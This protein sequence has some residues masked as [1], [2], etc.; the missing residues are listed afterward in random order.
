MSALTAAQFQRVNG[1]SN[2][3]WGWGGEDD[4][5]SNRLRYNGFHIARYPVNI[6]RYTMLGHKKEKANPKRYENLVSGV[7][8]FATDGLNSLR[9]RVHRL[10]KKVLY[11]WIEVEVLAAEAAS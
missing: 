9:Y 1:F 10:E 5:M 3:F 4:D 11:T 2:A 6:A 7:K 8:R